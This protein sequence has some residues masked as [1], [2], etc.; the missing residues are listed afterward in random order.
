M[1]AI[2]ERVGHCIKVLDVTHPEWV[3]TLMSWDILSAKNPM[4]MIVVKVFGGRQNALAELQLHC[5][6]QLTNYRLLWKYGLEAERKNG[7]RNE[8]DLH[9]LDAEWLRQIGARL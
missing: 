6:Q 1:N 5:S 9:A 2:A 7:N 8:D 3:S 4:R